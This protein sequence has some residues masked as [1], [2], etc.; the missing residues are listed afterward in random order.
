[1]FACSKRKFY[2]P[3]FEQRISCIPPFCTSCHGRS[4]IMIKS[5]A[6]VHRRELAVHHRYYQNP[7]AGV[8]LIAKCLSLTV[9]IRMDKSNRDMISGHMYNPGQVPKSPH[10]G[11]GIELCEA[12]CSPKK[13]LCAR[14]G[15]SIGMGVLGCDIVGVPKPYSSNGLAVQAYVSI[16]YYGVCVPTR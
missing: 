12:E 8:I 11:S 4:C 16:T 9:Y 5:I 1:M 14:G 3:A 6:L 13:L 2:F 10:R 15:A 7:E